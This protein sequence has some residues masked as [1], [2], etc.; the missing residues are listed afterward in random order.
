MSLPVVRAATALVWALAA[1]AAVYW[2]TRLAGQG[3]A[4][5]ASV[6]VAAPPAADAASVARL[7]GALPAAEAAAPVASRRKA[8][9][10]GVVA[11]VGGGAALIALD[12]GEPRP[13][14]VGADVADGYRLAALDTQAA[15]LVADGQPDWVLA[16]PTE[17]KSAAGAVRPV[18]RGAAAAPRPQPA[19]P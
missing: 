17:F 15:R 7:L 19:R 11:A 10:L 14:R 8:S 1:A 13:Y 6:A 3:D 16:M 4:A 5:V 2:G 9:L 18:A 12:D